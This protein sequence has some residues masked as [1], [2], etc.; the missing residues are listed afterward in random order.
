MVKG[1]WDGMRWEKEE[2]RACCMFVCIMAYASCL[3]EAQQKTWNERP[4][5]AEKDSTLVNCTVWA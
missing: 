5:T 2:Q 3:Q 1:R 4:R